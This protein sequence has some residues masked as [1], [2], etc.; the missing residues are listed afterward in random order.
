MVIL[1]VLQKKNE[2]SFLGQKRGCT[3]VISQKSN[4]EKH[5]DSR[6]NNGY[7]VNLKHIKV[8]RKEANIQL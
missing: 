8:N 4:L 1:T 5:L 6:H 3:G 2:T 7:Q